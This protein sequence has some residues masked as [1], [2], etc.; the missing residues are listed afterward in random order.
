MLQTHVCT[1][2]KRS[3]STQRS[4]KVCKKKVQYVPQPAM[5]GTVTELF[6]YCKLG[7]VLLS[8]INKPIYTT[9]QGMRT[10][11]LSRFS[12]GQ[13]THSDLQTTC[14]L[15]DSP[16]VTAASGK[17][18]F[19]EEHWVW[20]CV[21]WEHRWFQLL[22]CCKQGG[23][24]H[25]LAFQGSLSPGQSTC[26]GYCFTTSRP[27]PGGVTVSVQ[28][29]GWI[30]QEDQSKVKVYPMTIN[31]LVHGRDILQEFSGL[32]YCPALRMP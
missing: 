32:M 21:H 16:D 28:I 13:K 18:K 26:P 31:D 29:L 12:T 24:C 10:Q 25:S 20:M 22:G 8:T 2:G 9:L 6:K 15:Q 11:N 1:W 14:A 30:M 17:P 27:V 5:M 19:M 7:K 4:H 3:C 23:Q